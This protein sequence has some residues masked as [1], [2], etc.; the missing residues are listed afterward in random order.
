MRGRPV[1]TGSA[2]YSFVPGLMLTATRIKQKTAT[3]RD[4]KKLAKVLT[5][6]VFTEALQ[7][8]A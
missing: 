7:M 3:S 2:E 4:G 1:S 6:P 8:A 5:F